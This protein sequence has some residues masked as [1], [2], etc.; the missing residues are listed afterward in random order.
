MTLLVKLT[1]QID[2]GR[3]RPDAPAISRRGHGT[4]RKVTGC[5]VGPGQIDTR[6]HGSLD[7]SGTPGL[8]GGD[9]LLIVPGPEIEFAQFVVGVKASGS[10]GQSCAQI[11]FPIDSP[12][13]NRRVPSLGSLR[14]DRLACQGFAGAQV[15]SIHLA[16]TAVQSITPATVKFGLS[17]NSMAGAEEGAEA[18]ESA[19]RTRSTRIFQFPS[20]EAA[21]TVVERL[22]R[23]DFSALSGITPNRRGRKAQSHQL[24]SSWRPLRLEHPCV[25]ALPRASPTNLPVESWTVAHSCALLRTRQQDQGHQ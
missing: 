15:V 13:R 6:C 22:R 4:A 7:R 20:G 3:H 24:R 17:A 1:Q 2:A 8:Q 12:W 19:S 25:R 9:R 10:A 23:P 18:A 21:V 11:A 14:H 16:A 5:F